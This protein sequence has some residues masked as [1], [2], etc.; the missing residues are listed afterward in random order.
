V[1]FDEE[2]FAKRMITMSQRQKMHWIDAAYVSGHLKGFKELNILDIGCSDGAFT[3]LLHGI[4]ILFGTELNQD[5]AHKAKN[6]GISIVKSPQEVKADVLILR[7][8]IQH[9]HPEEFRDLLQMKARFIFILQSPN[10]SSIPYRIF[11]NDRVNLLKPTKEFSS[12]FNT[13]KL[14]ELRLALNENGYSI[15]SLEF[16]YLRT[17]YF[18][19]TFDLKEFVL[20]I[21]SKNRAYAG[22]FPGNIYRLAAERN[23]E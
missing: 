11:N 2:Y 1:D 23:N 10:L 15:K 19:P 17:P 8:T 22:S 13:M 14:R 6:L 5:E 18:R 7:G 21:F 4:G 12:M 16:P 3:K 20:S 9:L